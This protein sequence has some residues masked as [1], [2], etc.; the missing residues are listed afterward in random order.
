V[1][2]SRG[3]RLWRSGEVGGLKY[4]EPKIRDYGDLLDVTRA[5][6]AVGGEDGAGKSIQVTV[7]PLVQATVQLFP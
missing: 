5:S 2:D 3:V 4:E 1:P 6:G 7:D